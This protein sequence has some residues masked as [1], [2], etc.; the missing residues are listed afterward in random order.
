MKLLTT[1]NPKIIKGEKLAVRTAM[2]S[3]APHKTSGYNMC[4]KASEACSKYCLFGQGRG[5]MNA[6]QQAR[7]AKTYFFKSEPE[8]FKAQLTKEIETFVKS[9][10]RKGFKPAI[11]LNGYSDIPS[12]GIEFAKLFPEVTFYDY[13]KLIGTLKKELPSNYHLTFSR[14]ESNEAECKEAIALGFNVAVLF[15]NRPKTFWGLPVIDG[16][17]TDARFLDPKGVIVGL[18]PKGTVKKD[19][20]GFVVRGL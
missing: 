6:V 11:R 15:E 7:F 1:S 2:L 18:S 20:L 12:L 14:S 4:P 9:A 3:L 19:T 17:E 8:R 16:D 13:T 5:R 10:E